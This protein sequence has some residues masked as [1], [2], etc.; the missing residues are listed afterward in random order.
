MRA[1]D[2]GFVSNPKKIIRMIGIQDDELKILF[3]KRFIIGFESGVV[4]IKHWKIHN[5]I[6]NDRYH[7][8]KYLDEKNKII[9][10]KNGSYT[11]KT[12]KCIQNGYRMETEVR[13]GK[14]REGKFV[15][16]RDSWNSLV[17]PPKDVSGFKNKNAKQR[18]LPE[19]RKLTDDIEAVLKKIKDPEEEIKKVIKGY[20]SE[21][22]NRNPD[23]D[24]SNHRFSFYEFF[25]QKN[26][27]IKYKNK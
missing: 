12:G 20:A 21:I 1:D 19:C 25:K 4:V 10:K 8:T 26:G 18:L 27:Y 7:E 15:G 22:L 24:F 5:Y 3:S 13:L 14:V 23:N 9:E 11:D 16:L 6:Q 2:D 17:K